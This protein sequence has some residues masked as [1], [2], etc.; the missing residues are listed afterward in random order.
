MSEGEI[1]ARPE[2]AR[3]LLELVRSTPSW[4]GVDLDNVSTLARREMEVAE[5][6]SQG[7]SNK[8]IAEQLNLSEHTVK[9][10]L[11]RVFEKLGV[12]N[13][14]ELLFLLY[15][16]RDPRETGGKELGPRYS[17]LEGHLKAA[18]EGSATSQF[19]LGLAYTNGTGVDKSA[20][21]AYCWLRMAEQSSSVLRD[22]SRAAIA[23]LAGKLDPREIAVLDRK[24]ETTIRKQCASENKKF[25]GP[26]KRRMDL[27]ALR[28][29]V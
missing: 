10:Y 25:T 15:N 17:A 11:F 4:N 12:S 19:V 5:L 28:A 22:R 13:R 9:N 18:E 1:W 26:A 16:A 7:K 3:H 8:Q 14:S 21:S 24:V 2:E 6:A 29:V 20:K 27:P 23:E